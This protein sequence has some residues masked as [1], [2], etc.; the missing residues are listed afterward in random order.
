[1]PPAPPRSRPATFVSRP[2]PCVS[3]PS[4]RWPTGYRPTTAGRPSPRPRFRPCRRDSGPR[5]PDRAPREVD[6]RRARQKGRVCHCWL[7]RQCCRHCWA[8]Q[9]WHATHSTCPSRTTQAALA[10]DRRRGANRHR[11]SPSRHC[12]LRDRK[13][14]PARDFGAWHGA[15][16]IHRAALK[17]TG[18]VCAQHPPGRSAA[19]GTCPLRRRP[20]AAAAWAAEAAPA[21]GHQTNYGPVGPADRWPNVPA[22]RRR[23]ASGRHG[24]AA[25]GRRRF[26]R[27]RR[28][29]RARNGS[30]LSLASLL[31]TTVSGPPGPR[32]P[33]RDHLEAAGH[34]CEPNA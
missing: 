5:P 3:H 26:D 9:Q 16:P 2:P 24:V 34:P 29:R 13:V 10:F 7:A 20:C 6:R 17:G 15:P 1:M 11:R 31:R 33:A 27:H 30:L 25:L 22:G 19:N 4:G 21:G 28:H 12:R 18:P 32:R 8:S 23:Q 14:S